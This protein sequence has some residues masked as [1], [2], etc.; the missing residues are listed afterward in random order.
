MV[1]NPL[2]QFSHFL[3]YFLCFEETKKNYFFVQSVIN[4]FESYLA[5]ISSIRLI[6]H[7]C[8]VRPQTHQLTLFLVSY[9]EEMFVLTVIQ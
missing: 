2:K 6:C 9:I 7:S 4:L 3:L 8:Y 1:K 5:F